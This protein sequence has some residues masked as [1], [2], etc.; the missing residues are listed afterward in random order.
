MFVFKALCP[1][2]E[3]Q[4]GSLG[5]K[6]KGCV[7]NVLFYLCMEK[8]RLAISREPSQMSPKKELVHILALTPSE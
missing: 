3:G 5:L 6:L 1:A 2:A 7:V 8:F 4:I